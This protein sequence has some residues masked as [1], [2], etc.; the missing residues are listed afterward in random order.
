MK[1]IYPSGAAWLA[2]LPDLHQ[3]LQRE[4]SMR[5]AEMGC[6]DGW[7][8][9]DLARRYPHVRMDGFDLNEAIIDR[10]WSNA[11]ACGLTDRLTFHVRDVS[12]ATFNGRYDLCIAHQALAGMRNQFGV[13][14][15][16]HRLAGETGDVLVTAADRYDYAKTESWAN[17]MDNSADPLSAC[18]L[19]VGFRTVEVNSVHDFHLRC[20]R[21]YP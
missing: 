12:E 21:F 19:A 8:S 11:H 1:R 17:D 20:Y 3:R 5:I 14:A 13:L 16:M 7:F 6:G 2:T 4:P 15:T 10:A 18:A 9:I